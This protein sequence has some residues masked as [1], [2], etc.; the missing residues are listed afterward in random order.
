MRHSHEHVSTRAELIAK[1]ILI[2]AMGIIQLHTGGCVS[3]GTVARDH[4]LSP[5]LIDGWPR[6]ADHARR[7]GAA[8]SELQAFA[9]ALTARDPIDIALKWP[10]IRAKAYHG[11][12]EARAAGDIGEIGEMIQRD[13]IDTFD[14]GIAELTGVDPPS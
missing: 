11:I 7:G 4:A 13:Y 12:A 5:S 8:E 9:D 2:L 1:I 3:A 6:V 14:R 10:S